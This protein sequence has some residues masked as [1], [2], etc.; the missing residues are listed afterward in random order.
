MKFSVL[1]SVWKKEQ[2]VYLEQALDSLRLQSLPPNEVVLVEDG[3]LT[4]PLH[5]VIEKY[6]TLLPLKVRRL[7]TN[8]G[9]SE[10]LNAGL[11][12]C[13]NHWVARMDSDDVCLP[14]R[15]ANT[16]SFIAQNPDA[17]IVGSFANRINHNGRVMSLM[18]V[19][20]E[21]ARI[22]KLVWTCPL[23]H[24]TVCYRK[25]KIQALGGYS[26]KAGPR[27]DDYELWFRCVKAGYNI[28]NI[29]G[30]L[31]LYRFGVANISRNNYRVGWHQLKNG[32]R[33]NRMVGAGLLAYFGVAIPFFRSLLPYPL[34]L[35]VY[36]IQTRLNP[37]VKR[38]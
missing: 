35:W 28:Y 24:P 2:P 12:E 23:I 8:R 5:A 27:Q 33:G 4:A 29:P 9:L 25:D 36:N 22:R 21:P 10:A 19:P 34:N 3:P 32:I 30:P 13:T 7:E 14:E 20:V 31:L 37:R 16:A 18:R 17:D 38:D 6:R 1:M 15:L 11:E 26:P